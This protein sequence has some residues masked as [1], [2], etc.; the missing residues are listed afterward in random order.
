MKKKVT[1][2]VA[3]ATPVIHMKTSTKTKS[4]TILIM[5][6]IIKKLRK[7]NYLPFRLRYLN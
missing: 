1:I 3:G 7:I 4:S 2:D 5:H 6:E